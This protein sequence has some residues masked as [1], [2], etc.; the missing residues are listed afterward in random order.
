MSKQIVSTAAAPRAIGPYSQAV[1]TG[2]TAYLSGQLGMDPATGELEQGVEAQAQA[3]MKNIGA[4]LREAGLDYQQ[5]VKTTVFVKSLADFATVN[6]VYAS[7]FQGDYP[8]RSCV[9]VSALPKGALVEIE[10]VAAR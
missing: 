4:I 6:A 7:Y 3:A 1:L 10:C 8:A 9:E 5:I 2:D